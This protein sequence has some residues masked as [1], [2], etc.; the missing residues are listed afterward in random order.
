MKLPIA[1]LIASGIA[2]V[3][4][5]DTQR[6]ILEKL[7]TLSQSL[8]ELSAQ[9]EKQAIKDLAVKVTPLIAECKSLSK[10]IPLEKVI[11][12]LKTCRK[13]ARCYEEMH[14]NHWNPAERYMV[15]FKLSTEVKDLLKKAQESSKEAY[16][17]YLQ[18][19]KSTAALIDI[20]KF[21]ENTEQ[22]NSSSVQNN[23]NSIT[24][25]PV[26][27]SG[28]NQKLNALGKDNL[29]NIIE[30]AVTQ[31]NDAKDIY[32]ALA[33]ISSTCKTFNSIVTSNYDELHNNAILAFKTNNLEK[34]E[35]FL[36]ECIYTH[37]NID[38][39]CLLI[40]SP[41]F[42]ATQDNP[43]S[44]LRSNPLFTI[45][46]G[47]HTKGENPKEN[48]SVQP[49]W[50]SL[51]KTADFKAGLILLLEH[52]LET[53]PD[54][55]A[56]I[57]WT[58]AHTPRTVL[59]YLLTLYQ[60]S[61]LPHS[62]LEYLMDKALDKGASLTPNASQS[63]E[64]I[65]RCSSSNR[66]K[67]CVT[68]TPKLITENTGPNPIKI[69]VQRAVK[70]HKDDTT[71]LSMFNILIGINKNKKDLMDALSVLQS[72]RNISFD[73]KIAMH[74]NKLEPLLLN[75][76][77]Q[78]NGANLSNDFKQELISI[79]LEFSFEDFT[80]IIL[81]STR[82]F[83]Y[84]QVYNHPTYW[85]LNCRSYYKPRNVIQEFLSNCNHLDTRF[86]LL[87]SSITFNN[88]A[89]NNDIKLRLYCCLKNI[90]NQL[91]S[92]KGSNPLTELKLSIVH[93]LE[94]LKNRIENFNP[95]SFE[96]VK[97]NDLLGFLESKTASLSPRNTLA[98]IIIMTRNLQK[99]INFYNTLS[100]HLNDVSADKHNILKPLEK[101]L[102]DNMTTNPRDIIQ[103]WLQQC[104]NNPFPVLAVLKGVMGE[105]GVFKKLKIAD[106]IK[107]I[108][109]YLDKNPELY[110]EELK[111]VL[112]INNVS[113]INTA[114]EYK[115]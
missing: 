12:A 69:I 14:M 18:K 79:G 94:D 56:N 40:S 9:Q 38:A 77:K 49:L 66:F 107:I 92:L 70:T 16:Q 7:E 8:T 80:W 20:Q 62:I 60:E 109:N 114:P 45:K 96:N 58:R 101:I 41:Q 46:K 35:E 28:I 17:I 10:E 33:R 93:I 100:K 59:D 1:N 53:T 106:S 29:L 19:A 34:Y 99:N 85:F 89:I 82:N 108:K 36:F 48:E 39:L 3:V 6:E 71:P 55:N 64:D 31:P 112:G 74:D 25:S 61:Y 68:A 51:A 72:L 11:E 54:I 21:V 95:T 63:L 52:Y 91:W 2:N 90:S 47:G 83:T 88:D 102:V 105:F 30:Y 87:I 113:N 4:F 32:K 15:S 57:I 81:T 98:E 22:T 24:S 44:K 42:S 27:L 26:T 103:L 111:T 65:L 97:L 43:E 84:R 37:K 50:F 78:I 86:L 5:I 75:I 76:L 104:P 110:P 73:Q 115:K 23:S 13:N 67:E